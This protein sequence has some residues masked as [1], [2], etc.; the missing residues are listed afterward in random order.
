MIRRPPRSTRTD[1]LF[2][3]TTLF[4]SVRIHDGPAH[5]VAPRMV[6]DDPAVV[7]VHVVDGETQVGK[8][9]VRE[10]VALADLD[11]DAV[12]A[13]ADGVADH[14]GAGGVPQRDAIAGLRDAQVPAPGDDVALHDRI[15][16]A[17]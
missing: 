12:A 5:V 11:E 9:V 3:Y 17:V 6:A 15:F 1:T 2:P 13:M 16:G 8:G 10:R 7:G 14:P 4:R